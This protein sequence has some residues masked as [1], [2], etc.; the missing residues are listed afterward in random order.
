MSIRY[1]NKIYTLFLVLSSTLCYATGVEGFESG[2]TSGS[3][4]FISN[5]KSFVLGNGF[6]VSNR[7]NSGAN[8]SDWFIE[9][10]SCPGRRSVG[11]INTANG[12]NFY[13]KSISVFISNNCNDPVDGRIRVLWFKNGQRVSQ[14]RYNINSATENGYVNLDVS[15]ANNECIS[16]DSVVF[17]LL[18]SANSIKIDDFE[19]S[20]DI[21]NHAT[22]RG[23]DYLYS[24]DFLPKTVN[25]QWLDCSNGCVDIPSENERIF[26]AGVSGSYAVRV[27][28]EICSFTSGAKNINA[29]RVKSTPRIENFEK[30]EIA[31]SATF[32]NSGRT[33]NLGLWSVD[34]FEFY[35]VD[36]TDWYI[37]NY[38]SCLS[39]VTNFTTSISTANGSNFY[40]NGGWFFLSNNCDTPTDGSII[41]SWYKNGDYLNSK[42]YGLN[43][44]TSEESSNGFVYLELGDASD[45]FADSLTFEALGD[46]TYLAIDNFSWSTRVKPPEESP[47]AD[48]LEEPLVEELIPT[49][50]VLEVYP[51]PIEDYMVVMHP[52]IKSGNVY[53]TNIYGSLVVESE[54]IGT[55]TRLNTAS[56]PSGV[57][58]IT[59]ESNNYNE[60]ITIM[61]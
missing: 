33:F 8:N 26:K 43:N 2:Q 37:D 49:K 19:W 35:G 53:V 4:S 6:N 20:S 16:A 46:I 29:D 12:E 5:G 58:I 34:N 7:T 39:G 23:G 57:Y 45:Y 21:L 40:F 30:N 3:F 51:N 47:S 52:E 10:T 32:L 17:K 56:L 28:D 61:K 60:V 48:Q 54:I 41:V 18:R 27:S 31:G 14:I 24:K 22:I 9:H 15:R 36:T 42:T 59:I 44:S 55:Q 50:D 13:L 11:S 38:T 1:M 25:Y